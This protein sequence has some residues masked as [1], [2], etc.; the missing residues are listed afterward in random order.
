MFS[1]DTDKKKKKKSKTNENSIQNEYRVRGD[2]IPE[3]I[4]VT[5]ERKQPEN[6]DRER[7]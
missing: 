2:N 7:E 3:S 4:K 5:V 6:N 1:Y